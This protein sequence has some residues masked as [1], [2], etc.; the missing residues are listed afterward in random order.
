MSWISL[1]FRGRPDIFANCKISKS[2]LLEGEISYEDPAENSFNDRAMWT[3][4][5]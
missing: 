3:A 2:L 5:S 4:A 1:T